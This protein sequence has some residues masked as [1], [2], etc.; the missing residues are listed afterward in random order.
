[1]GLLARLFGKQVLAEVDN[2]VHIAGTAIYVRLVEKYGR[3]FDKCEI[4][5]VSALAAAVTNEL[6]GAPPGNE[7]GRQF[8]VANRKWVDACLRELKEEPQICYI[9]SLL[10]HTRGNAAGNSGTVTPGMLLSWRKLRQEGILLPIEQIQLSH[11]P[12]DLE[13]RVREFEVWSTKN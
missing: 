3:K 1:M 6:F 8:L 4:N 11:S 7:K 2:C 12:E 9:V 5:T 13:R 10:T